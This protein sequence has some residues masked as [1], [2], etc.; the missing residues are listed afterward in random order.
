ML[1][2]AKPGIGIAG[3]VNVS[4]SSC[5]APFLSQAQ[6]MRWH[7]NYVMNPSWGVNTW[8]VCPINFDNDTLPSAFVVGVIGSLM[9]G[10]SSERPNCFFTVHTAVNTTQPPFR[11][12]NDGVLT[13]PLEFNM[14]DPTLWAAGRGISSVDVAGYLGDP[15]FWAMAVYCRLPVGYSISQVTIGDDF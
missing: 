5:Q 9:D 13:W 4:P 3:D 15:D 14:V 1:M 11:S 2:L 8:L 7:E 10:A 6:G 12:G